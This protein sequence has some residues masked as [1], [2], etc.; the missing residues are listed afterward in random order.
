MGAQRT[1][2]GGTCVGATQV[3]K[4]LIDAVDLLA[5]S[6]ALHGDGDLSGVS[7]DALETYADGFAEEG[8]KPTIQAEIARRA[9]LQER[10]I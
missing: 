3:S 7:A 8:E 5:I 2:R 6:D 10:D 4:L 1:D 9:A